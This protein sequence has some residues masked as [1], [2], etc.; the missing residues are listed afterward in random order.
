MY[1]YDLSTYGQFILDR[2]RT[3]AYCQALARAVKPGDVVVD[4]GAG[5]GIF[6][7]YACRLGAR[8][9]HAIEPNPAIQVA[10]EIVDANGFS[11]RV[12]FY[13]TMSFQVELPELCDVVVTDPRG[14]LP[15]HE[16][17]IPTIIDARRRLL[18]PG[19]VLIPQRD[20]IWAALVEAPDIYHERCDNAWR[21][22]NDGFDMEAAR[23]RVVNSTSR[24]RIE[25]SQLLSEPV[26]WLVL[27]YRVIEQASACGSVQFQAKQPG[28][29]HGFALWFDSE[30]IDGICMSNCPGQ[31]KLLY[32]Q[33]FFP[34][35]EPLFVSPN[36]TITVDLRVDPVGED[37]VY[38][39]TTQRTSASSLG[40]IETLYHQSSFFSNLLGSNQLR[41]MSDQHVPL[42]NEEGVV[43]MRALELMNSRRPLGQ[44]AE[45][46]AAE[47]PK[48]FSSSDDALGFVADLSARW[49]H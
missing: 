38:Q 10:R 7:L 35:Q 49:S 24:P 6:T 3:E 39:W 30:L 47:F 34:F 2:V 21:S 28:T 45:A 42:L 25:S 29:A 44:I 14:V 18:K 15:F 1:F 41:K 36:Q 5:A 8:Q 40:K 22:A 46:M 11:Q 33:L 48:R 4:L 23:R 9:V 31:P 27:D 16:K 17:A 20:A 12:T 26:C 37:Y 19:G 32:G 13:E 43:Q